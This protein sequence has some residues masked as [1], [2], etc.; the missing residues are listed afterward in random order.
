MR[1]SHREAGDES[2]KKRQRGACSLYKD[3][4]DRKYVNHL[5]PGSFVQFL[6]NA[7]ELCSASLLI[8]PSRSGWTSTPSP[9]PLQ[10]GLFINRLKTR[11]P[12]PR[13]SRKPGH[14]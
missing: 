9:N 7:R 12:A 2:E 1:R 3:R 11:P 5:M 10:I 14:P 13:S 4:K 6:L 8:S